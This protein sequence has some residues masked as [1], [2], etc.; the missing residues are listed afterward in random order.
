MRII[1]TLSVNVK[2][3]QA[4]KKFTFDYCEQ[5]TEI[6]SDLSGGTLTSDKSSACIN[7][8]SCLEFYFQIKKQKSYLWKVTNGDIISPLPDSSDQIQVKWYSFRS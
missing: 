3:E 6:T 2:I 4:I 5:L 8:E 7:G 1:I